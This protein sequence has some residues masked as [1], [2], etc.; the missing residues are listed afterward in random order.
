MEGGREGGGEG[1]NLG[2]IKF[3]SGRGEGRE[4]TIRNFLN[5]STRKGLS[6][7]TTKAKMEAKGSSASKSGE[8]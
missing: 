5:I 1:L 7:H 6:R 8:N 4:T 2:N 3:S